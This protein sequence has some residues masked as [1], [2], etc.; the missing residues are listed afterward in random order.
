MIIG[1]TGPAGSGKSTAANYLVE[2]HGF[3][4]V[5]F[6]GPLKAMI[7]TLCDQM[8]VPMHDREAMIEGETKDIHADALNM[9]TPRYAMQTLGTEWGRN[10]MGED[11]WVNVTRQ[12]IQNEYENSPPSFKPRIVL[13]DVRFENEAALIRELGGT[14]VHIEGRGGIEGSH[15]SEG[16]IIGHIKDGVVSN[17]RSSEHLFGL[18]DEIVAAISE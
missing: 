7:R 10:C 14:V 2:S 17:R 15:V 16:G 11:F 18:L 4:F 6:A 12:R 3:M 9:H 13:D 8:L 5:K 1:F